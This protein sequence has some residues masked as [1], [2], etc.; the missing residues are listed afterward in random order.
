MD[1]PLRFDRF[2]DESQRE[3]RPSSSSPSVR[4]VDRR[5]SS[6]RPQHDFGR[7]GREEV[8]SR[9]G[10]GGRGGSGD[11]RLDVGGQEASELMVL[12]TSKSSCEVVPISAD[13]VPLSRR[14]GGSRRG[15][16]V[17]EG[18]ATAIALW[19][20]AGDEE[21]LLSAMVNR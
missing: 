7:N 14:E 19:V 6:D 18:L 4:E 17:A 15:G 5:R 16:M 20:A 21:G 3:Q 8:R 13:S 11:T 1:A 9:P 2:D 12:A 10:S